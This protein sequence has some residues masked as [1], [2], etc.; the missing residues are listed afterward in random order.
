MSAEPATNWDQAET[1][2]QP[3]PGTS[4]SF[5]AN[6]SARAERFVKLVGDDL[7]YVHA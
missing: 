2:P 1:I 6:D 5:P 4:A 7:R 3:K